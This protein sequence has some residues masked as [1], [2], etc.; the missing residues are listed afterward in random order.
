MAWS[1]SPSLLGG[2]Y[3]YPQSD[4]SI[5]LLHGSQSSPSGPLWHQ[6]STYLSPGKHLGIS[7]KNVIATC[8]N[9]LARR[10]DDIGRMQDSVIKSRRTN[11]L[12]FEQRHSSWM[13]DFDFKPGALV[14]VRVRATALNRHNVKSTP[15]KSPA[16]GTCLPST[17]TGEGTWELREG[18]L[19][20]REWPQRSYL[21]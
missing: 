10:P 5:S 7:T 1:C 11:L 18:D 8:A 20:L 15:G 9:W 21:Q 4:W 13:I 14:L 12:R 2:R 19:H 3:H 6:G 16:A 17:E